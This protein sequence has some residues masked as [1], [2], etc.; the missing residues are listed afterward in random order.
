MTYPTIHESLEFKAEGIS[1]GSI[2]T[3]FDEFMRDFQEFKA[4]NDERLEQIERR[5]SADVITA[6]KLDRLN[7]ALD[8]QKRTLDVLAL[9]AVRPVRGGTDNTWAAPNERKTAFESYMRRG[10]TNAL[11][12]LEEKAWSAGSPTDGGLTIPIEVE[13][14]ITSA[15]RQVSPIRAIAANRQVSGTLYKKPFASSGASVGWVGEISARPETGAPV[16]AELTFPT[17]ELYAMPAATQTLLDDSSTNI[18]EWLAGEVRQ[19][20]AEQEN[21]AFVSGDGVNKP[22]GFLSYPK[23]ANSGWTWGKIG[24]FLSGAAGAFPAS[25][26]AD[27]LIDLAYSLKTPYR[28]NGHWAMNRATQAEIRKLKDGE[29]NYLWRPGQQAGADASLMGFPIAEIEEMPSIAANAFALAFGDF[30][31]G[32]LVVDRIGVSVL[33]DPYSAKPYV[34]FYTTKRVGG[35]VQDFDAIKLLKFSAS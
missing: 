16:L 15:L 24:Y 35:G 25:N 6:D 27:V 21:V 2:S 30:S 32:Y 34:L 22:Q 7:H 17:M 13:N 5:M 1:S 23:A 26:A 12:G 4:A 33:R 10:E 19:A 20:F 9:K 14:T 8:E 28:V 29:G 18:E 31:R 3:A 11:R